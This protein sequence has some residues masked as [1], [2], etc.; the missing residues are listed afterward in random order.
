M[1]TTELKK[2]A[3]KY[4]ANLIQSTNERCLISVFTD[5]NVQ[6]IFLA[7]KKMLR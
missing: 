3:M 2:N 5:S 4:Q 7:E 6:L 1:T